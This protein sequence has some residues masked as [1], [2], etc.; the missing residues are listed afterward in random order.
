MSVCITAQTHALRSTIAIC[1]VLLIAL[2]MLVY[3]YCDNDIH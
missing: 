1:Q 3:K 2:E